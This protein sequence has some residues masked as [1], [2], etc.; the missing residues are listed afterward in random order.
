MSALSISL[1]LYFLI[2][3]LLNNPVT[4]FEFAPRTSSLSLNCLQHKH[5]NP[6]SV[7]VY[8]AGGIYDSSICFQ[9]RE[10]DEDLYQLDAGV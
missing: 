10:N 7:R 3:D 8:R 9:S 6:I 4:Q 5:T 1:G 2:N